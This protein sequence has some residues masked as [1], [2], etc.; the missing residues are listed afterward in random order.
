M[1]PARLLV[2]C[3]PGFERECAQ[4]VTAAAGSMGVEG[5]VKARPPKGARL[6]K[7]RGF[8]PML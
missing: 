8:V 7:T 1:K 6:E 5:C 2:Y 3:R 4:V